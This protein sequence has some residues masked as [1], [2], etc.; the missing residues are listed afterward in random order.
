MKSRIQD[1]INKEVLIPSSERK[2]WFAKYCDR[3]RY[4]WIYWVKENSKEQ[5]IENLKKVAEAGEDAGG[6]AA[7][8][9]YA[10]KIDA[11]KDSQ[12]RGVEFDGVVATLLIEYLE[13]K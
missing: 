9:L 10:G 4:L 5:A 7:N 2:E 6:R 1:L 3:A 8:S 12:L 11:E 13:S